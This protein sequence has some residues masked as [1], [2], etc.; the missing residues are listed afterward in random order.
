MSH[1]LDRSGPKESHS[2]AFCSDKLRQCVTSAS[3]VDSWRLINPSAKSFTFFSATHKSYSRIDYIFI[4]TSLSSAVRDANI[5][6]LSL[7]DHDGNLCRLSLI[8]RP[9]RATRW[10]FNPK[11]LQDENFCSQFRNK[12]AEFI[13]INQGS[14]DDPRTLWNAVKG[15][16]RNN[17]ISYASFLQKKRHKKIA[18]LE[19]QLQ[20]LT[21]DNQRCFSD[22][23]LSKI[24]AVRSELNSLLRSRAEFLIQRCRQNYYFQGSRPSHLLA[25]RIRNSEKFANISAVKSQSGLIMTDP[26]DINISF[27]SFYSNLYTS[28]AV[29]DPDSFTS[30]LSNLDLPRLSDSDSDYLAEP[31]TLQELE[32]AIRSMNKGKSPGL[33]GIPV[34]LYST[35]WSDLGPLMLDMI[36]FSVSQGSFHPSINIAVI[37]LLLKKDKDP[38]SCSSYRPLSLIGTDVKLYAKVLSRR[39]EKFMNRLVHHDQTGFIKSRSASDN[40][41]RLYHIINSTNSSSSPCAVLSLDAMKAFDQ[42][43]WNYLWAVLQHLGLGSSFINMI[44]VLYFNPA[45]S[46]LT[47]SVC[48]NPFFIHRGTRQGCPLSPLLFALSLEP[49]AQAVRRSQTISPII[50]RNTQHHISL[51]ADDILLFLEKPSHSIPHV[52]NLFDHFG[53]LSGFKINWSKSCLLPLNSKFDPTSLSASIPLVQNFKYLGINVFPSLQEILSKNYNSILSKISSDLENWSRLPTSLQARISVIKMNVL[54][55]INFFSSMIPLPPPVGYWNKLDACVSRYIWNGK[56]PRIKLTTLQRSRLHGGLS[57][58]NFR[59]YAQ[60]FSLRPLSVWFDPDASVSWRAIEESIVYPYKLKHLVFSGVP[61][62]Q[63][64][65]RFG[66]IVTHLL[67]TWRDVER[68]LQLVTIWH[69]HSPIFHNNNLLS[70]NT[71]FHCPQ[72]THHKVNTL[73]DIYD[74]SGL[75]SFQNLKTQYNLPG[76]SFFMYLRIRSALRAYG[77]PWNSQLPIHPLRKL[78]LPSEEFPSSASVIYL[79]LLEHSYKPLSI[80][81]V[82]A[83]DLNEDVHVLFSDQ[84]WGMFK[85]SSKNPNHQMIHWKLLHRVYLT[86]MKRFHMN[87]S[88]SPKCN[89]CSQGSLGTF[90]HFFWE[91]PSLSPFWSQLS[92]DLSYLLG[93]EICLTPRHFFMNDFWDLTLS[94][95]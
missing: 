12:F 88:S 51:F 38:T 26:K 56:R 36:N 60:A 78:I 72:W 69:K 23:T 34:E 32:S 53:S 85:L 59:L 8:P 92:Q 30:F 83:K 81:T 62:R 64:K 33:D 45:A 77:V 93:T 61:L 15:F 42:L 68:R 37:S 7:S 35:F 55:R 52:L 89:L 95:Q 29:G 66:P 94:V 6:S 54:P 70:G 91:C 16:I 2:Q 87:L 49:L 73:G 44:K 28:S 46:V 79:F 4:S 18:E 10:R 22:S 39:L 90:L 63:C 14:V 86:P 47:G 3:L 27:H 17:S 84:I 82:W 57:L 20:N 9:S 41:R 58:P 24:M 65:S 1:I 76:T 25:L 31:I 5:C 48:S 50:I 40:L 19:S 13:E 71:P 75:Q 67:S 74:D 80:T 43:E 11:L 21:R